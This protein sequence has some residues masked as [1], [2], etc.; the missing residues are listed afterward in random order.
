MSIRAELAAVVLLSMAVGLLPLL[1]NGAPMVG[2]SWIHM[3][4]AERIASTGGYSMDSY[5]TFWP[6]VNMLLAYMMMVPSLPMKATMA[7]VPILVGL[8]SLPLLMAARLFS[9]SSRAYV[10]APVLL[11]TCLL[12]SFVVFAGSIMKETSAYYLTVLLIYLFSRHRLPKAAALIVGVGI[13][14]G[15]HYAGLFST[16]FL[17]SCLLLCRGRRAVAVV[18][19]PL[20]ASYVAWN[21]WAYSSIG[22]FFPAFSLPGIQV[23]AMVFAGVAGLTLLV[24]WPTLVALSVLSVLLGAWGLRG[25]LF[26]I[27]HREP[28]MGFWEAKNYAIYAL[29]PA[30]GLVDEDRGPVS[31]LAASSISL[32]LFPFVWGRGYDSLVL[33]TKSLHYFALM[34]AISGVILLAR[35]PHRYRSAISAL[36]IAILIYE[37]SYSGLLAMHGLSA[38]RSWEVQGVESLSGIMDPF[39][40]SSDTRLGYLASYSGAVHGGPLLIS[41]VNVEDGFLLGYDWVPLRSILDGTGSRDR[42]YD[43][44]LLMLWGS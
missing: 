33:L 29:L 7:I 18:A 16:L 13:V 40:V 2:D 4:M 39:R 17:I 35:V 1:Y 15:H 38:Y 26:T 12:F 32:F 6:L 43:S 5:N 20:V 14:L 31:A 8:S 3:G 28:P 44:G 24:G 36:L 41:K 9:R 10:L 21:Y 19:V 11:F 22:Q 23:L 37:S 34:V 27:L 30:G 42:L 25:G